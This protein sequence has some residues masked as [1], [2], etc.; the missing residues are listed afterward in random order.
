MKEAM[1][2]HPGV[3][4]P[5]ERLVPEGGAAL[6]GRNLRE[7]T[8][9]G[10]NPVVVH[11]NREIFGDDAAEFRPERWLEA[12]SEQTKIMER[13]L[14]AVSLQLLPLYCCQ[15]PLPTRAIGVCSNKSDVNSL[16]SLV[17]EPAPVLERIFH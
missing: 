11:Q 15:L 3:S 14:L 8:N 12:D 17:L 1:R 10:I 6:C 7:G 2:L 13:T 9:V 16:T 4:Y 5:L